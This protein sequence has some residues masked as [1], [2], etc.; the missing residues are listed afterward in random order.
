[1]KDKKIVVGVAQ[2]LLSVVKLKAG[3][4]KVI[5]PYEELITQM[6]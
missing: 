6:S 3:V 1:M 5:T 4:M 2:A